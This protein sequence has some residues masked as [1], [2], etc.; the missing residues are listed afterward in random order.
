MSPSQVTKAVT[1]ETGDVEH[2]KTPPLRGLPPE[3]AAPTWAWHGQTD[4]GP[5]ETVVFQKPR[6]ERPSL[7]KVSCKQDSK[8]VKGS[9]G[10]SNTRPQAALTRKEAQGWAGQG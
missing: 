9:T 5:Q 3:E 6:R 10:L 2:W 7:G 4:G 1:A 8:T